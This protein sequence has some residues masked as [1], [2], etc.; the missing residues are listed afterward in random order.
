MAHGLDKAMMHDISGEEE[1]EVKAWKAR[2]GNYLH[3]KAEQALSPSLVWASL[4]SLLRI[5][6]CNFFVEAPQQP[7]A[8]TKKVQFRPLRIVG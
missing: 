2:G 4:H 8:M 1:D 6:R 3:D 7:P 5:L